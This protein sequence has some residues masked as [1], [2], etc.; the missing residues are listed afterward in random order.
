MTTYKRTRV[1]KDGTIRNDVYTYNYM[2]KFDCGCGS[3]VC[4]THKARHNKSKKH[5]KWLE[6]SN[7]LA[8]NLNNDL[9]EI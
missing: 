6:Q 9:N 5:K 7:I 8:H 4:Q 2:K 1:L 3:K